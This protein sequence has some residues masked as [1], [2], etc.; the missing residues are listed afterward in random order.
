MTESEILKVINSLKTK[1]CELDTIPTD[2]LKKMLPS[3]VPLITKIANLSLTKGEF[4]RSWKI[5]VVQP[6]LKKLG[7][8]LIHS[9]YRPV[10]NL[11]FISKI[12][13]RCM[14]LQASNHCNTYNLQPDYQSAY[15]ENY[16]C[17]TA[18]LHV[19][20][21]ILW[22]MEH[23]SIT[24]LVAMDLSVAFNTV[25]H[26]ILLT[27]LRCKFGIEN[28]ALQ[29]FDQYLHPRSYKVIVNGKYSRKIDLTLSVPQGSCVG[30]NIFNLYCSPLQDI[31]PESLQISGF[32]D[33]H[34]IRR[35]FKAN[36][37]QQELEVKQDQE[38]CMLN[39]KK[40]MDQCI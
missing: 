9:N 20:N 40:W 10:S 35:S 19:S 29:W 37:R 33:D 26:D 25:D 24:S 8:Q 34:S 21:D 3:I 38:H 22:V 11:T 30:A 6:L 18:I 16:S 17:E 1:S 7:L 12:I 4:C 2:I 14:L 23:Q 5:A 15:R 31:V 39:I 36:N 28:K 27:I 32:A 13:E